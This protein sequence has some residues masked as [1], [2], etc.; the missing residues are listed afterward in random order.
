MDYRKIK[1]A[2]FWEINIKIW[3]DLMI[4]MAELNGLKSKYVICSDEEKFNL[5]APD[6]LAYY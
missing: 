4:W 5:D 2:F 6:V 1:K 3:I